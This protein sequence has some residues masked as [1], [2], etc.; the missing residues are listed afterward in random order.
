M[1]SVSVK[2][3]GRGRKR[4]GAASSKRSSGRSSRTVR[5]VVDSQPPDPVTA[6]AQD[7]VAGA[8]VAGRAVR[9]ACQRHLDD[10]QR[11]VTPAFPYVFEPAR[12]ADLLKF[13]EDFCTLDD[14]DPVTGDPLPFTLVRWQQFVLGSLVGWVHQRTG[15]LRFLESY[16]ETGKGS[17]KTPASAAY[18]LYRTV[19]WDRHNLENYSAGVNG[20]QANYLFAFAKR[21]AQ[22]SPDLRALLD[23]GEYNLAWVERNSFFRPLT[24]EGRS[25]DNKRVFTAIIDELHEHPSPVIPEKMLL[26][27]KSQTDAQVL[28]LT[29]AG[30]DKTSVCW[31]K[32][33]YGMKVLEGA[34]VDEAFFAYICQLDACETCRAKG[35]TQPN[36][37]CP[38]CDDWTNEPVWTKVNPAIDD[39]PA[40]R[41]YLRG[42]V[43]RAVNQ[44]T[45]QSRIKRLNFCIWTQAHSV[46]IPS[47]AWAACRSSIERPKSGV[48]C[49]AAFD[50]SMKVD[51]S[52]C[53]IAQ[54]F[55]D[56]P[57]AKEE[58]IEI[59]T[60][61]AGQNLK[62]MWAANYRIRLSAFAWLPEDTLLERV[63]SERIPYDLWKR[64]SDDPSSPLG[65]FF[66]TTPGPV[67]D[68]HQ[69]V[70]EFL[71]EIGATFRPQRIGYDPYN[72]TA[73]AIDLRDR[74][75]YSIVELGQGRKLSETIKLF[76][77]LVRLGRI[78]HDGNPLFAWCISNAEPK[79]DRFE[80]VW[81]EKPSATKR[82]DLA[83]AAVM[84]VSQVVLL[85]SVR[86]RRRGAR[87][88]TPA[89]FIDAAE[90]LGV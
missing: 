27:V 7:V 24:S 33:D 32:H 34:I 30:H 28:M 2:A 77:A 72:A 22:R 67:I 79:Y 71:E 56:P 59:E 62:R 48:A 66:R 37:G 18:G 3:P 17:T 61:D 46:W 50:M 51:L 57:E 69:I 58:T 63:Q 5:G 60:I 82:I 13:F 20:D 10:L 26:G 41:E 8:V 80:N 12:V 19:A 81:L 4:A 86:K 38:Q 83:I 53:V 90:Y 68:H 29:N 14:V 78:E 85:P 88:W 52:G 65:R 49:A 54:R 9:L 43:R 39:I 75:K 31:T 70:D 73:L 76:Y 15:F 55:D 47:N 64:M 11:Q 35:A 21:I 6:Y 25:L 87:I 89:G 36:D 40:L 74:G 84:A 23:V 42:V 16:E 44:P 1:T 45:T